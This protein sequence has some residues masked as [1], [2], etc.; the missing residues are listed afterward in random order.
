M[1]QSRL[2]RTIAVLAVA[3]APARFAVAQDAPASKAAV[4]TSISVFLDCSFQC[5][6]DYVHTEIGYV[7]WVRD[8]AVADVHVL[9][10]TQGTG[11]GG[12]EF[13]FAFLGLRVFSGV[14]D[15]LHYVAAAS[16][17]PDETRKG[18]VH[19]L[20][21]GLVPFL[22]RSALADRLEITVKKPVAGA[23]L[24]AQAQ[25]DPWNF[26]VFTTSF[27]GDGNG[28]RNNTFTFLTGRFNASRT[29]QRW[30]INLA[31]RES[32]NQSDFKIDSVTTSTF[33]RRSYSFD[34]LV[35]K[36]IGARWAAGWRSSIGSSTFE[37]KRFSFDATPAVE[38]DIF[39]YSE[40]TRRMMTLQYAI[41]IEGFRY[42]E[43]TIYGKLDE[44]RPL[45]TLSLSLSQNQPWGAVNLGLSSGQYLNETSKNYA[46]L[47][48][49][50]NVRL[51]K[52]FNF[53]LG[54]NY[55]AIRN[56]IF[57]PRRGATEEEILTQQRQLATNYQYFVFLGINYT[58]G[59]VLNNIVNPRFGRDNGGG[60][61]IIM[62]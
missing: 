11:G 18:V 45:H 61:T 33:I 59:S 4:P 2:C 8:R 48:G 10:T 40:S 16:A 30:K 32:Y 17:T 41:G 21:E 20:E 23:P 25:H 54:G 39:P 19:V 44:T 14:G 47:F 29:T 51:F 22:A 7:N 62:F 28:D 52:G 6:E 60:G 31:A 55:S 15:T 46:T 13:T 58:F 38:F 49:S 26:W 1:P 42:E 24:V 35:V 27:S 57:L 12:T 43:E 37:N 36:S 9:V 56:Q 50:M 53:N 5:D 34:Q 3:C